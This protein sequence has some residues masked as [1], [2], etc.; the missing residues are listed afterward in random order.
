[1]LGSRFKH[2]LKMKGRGRERKQAAP[3]RRGRRRGRPLS[4]RAALPSSC[5]SWRWPGPLAT[6][7]PFSVGHGWGPPTPPP[8]LSAPA[9]CVVLRPGVR[10]LR[11]VG[12]RLLPPGGGVP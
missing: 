5:S 2:G 4:P 11:A 6:Q 12:R 3:T 1:M 9:P 8:S 7:C 10:G